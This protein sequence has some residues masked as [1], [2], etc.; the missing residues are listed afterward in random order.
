MASGPLLS[1]HAWGIAIDLNNHIAGWLDPD[2]VQPEGI[3]DAFKKRGFI[4]GGDWSEQYVDMM[5]FQACR[6]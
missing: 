1:T 3:V 4:W 5:H 6:A 2:G